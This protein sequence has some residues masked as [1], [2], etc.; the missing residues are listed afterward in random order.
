MIGAAEARAT[1]WRRV[2]YDASIVVHINIYVFRQGNGF[3]LCYLDVLFYSENNPDLGYSDHK[4]K[5]YGSIV[6]G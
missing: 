4:A 5:P 2:L 1:W 3:F 6:L